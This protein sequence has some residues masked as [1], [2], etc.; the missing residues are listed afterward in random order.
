MEEEALLILARAVTSDEQSSLGTAGLGSRM[1][2][3]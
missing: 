1:S 3:F 2:A